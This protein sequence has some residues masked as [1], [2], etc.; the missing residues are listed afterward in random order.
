MDLLDGRMDECL[1][2]MNKGV[3]FQLYRLCCCWLYSSASNL[4]LQIIVCVPFPRFPFFPSFLPCPPIFIV[5]CPFSFIWLVVCLMA[6]RVYDGWSLLLKSLPFFIARTS[7]SSSWLT[8]C[9]FSHFEQPRRCSSVSSPWKIRN[10]FH[11][12]SL[13]F[14]LPCIVFSFFLSRGWTQYAVG[15]INGRTSDRLV[16]RRYKNMKGEKRTPK[17]WIGTGKV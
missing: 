10:L 17:I 15:L 3:L 12:V 11:L 13:C 6:V 9:I 14:L 8:W 5:H 7:Y 4:S 16:I 2:I 1:K